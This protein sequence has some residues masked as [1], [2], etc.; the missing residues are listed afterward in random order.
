MIGGRPPDYRDIIHPRRLQTP[1]YLLAA[2]PPCIELRDEAARP[3]GRDHRTTHLE[4]LDSLRP[5]P[6]SIVAVLLCP[7]DSTAD[8]V[9]WMATHT[10]DA[11]RVAFF[12]HPA[13]DAADALAPWYAAGH[14]D[15]VAYEAETWMDVAKPLGQ[16][17]NDWIYV[18][19][20][21]TGWPL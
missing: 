12:V 4:S 14:P 13:T 7:G 10:I 15:P 8:L 3:R 16:F 11:E 21:G 2:T 1:V 19:A 20:T 18:D 6:R 5:A 17:V 9:A